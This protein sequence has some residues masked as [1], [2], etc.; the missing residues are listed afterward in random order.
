MNRHDRR[1]CENR[2]LAT[3]VFEGQEQRARVC[4]ETLVKEQPSSLC[5][6]CSG[7]NALPL[8]GGEQ[9]LPLLHTCPLPLPPP[10]LGSQKRVFG[11]VVIFRY[12]CVLQSFLQPFPNQLLFANSDVFH[13]SPCETSKA[14]SLSP[15]SCPEEQAGFSLKDRG[16]QGASTGTWN[17]PPPERAVSSWKGPA[18]T[19]HVSI[20]GVLAASGLRIFLCLPHKIRGSLEGGAVSCSSF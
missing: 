7:E 10:R 6:F 5:S 8:V 15:F 13:W 1:S 16:F 20:P 18:F 3:D 14:W 11:E 9:S 4:Q 17:R 19:Q 12:L 2:A